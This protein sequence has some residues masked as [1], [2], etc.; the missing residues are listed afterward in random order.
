M[1]RWGV[2]VYISGVFRFACGVDIYIC[3]VYVYLWVGYRCMY[4]R[5]VEV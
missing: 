2:K 5:C 1:C 4:G 3:V